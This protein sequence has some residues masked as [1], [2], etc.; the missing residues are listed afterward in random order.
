MS[1]EHAGRLPQLL[2]SAGIAVFLIAFLALP[3]AAQDNAGIASDEAL[4]V[5]EDDAGRYWGKQT[6]SATSQAPQYPREAAI[7]GASGCVNI[8]FIIQPDGT[9]TGY[10]RL[11]GR[12]SF[13][14]GGQHAAVLSQFTRST[15]AMLKKWRYQPG[16]DNPDR[17]RG[18]ASLHA[19][20]SLDAIGGHEWT[21]ACR[22][23]K[24]GEFIQSRQASPSGQ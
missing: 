12:S 11:I 21:D 7:A 13:H 8:G 10:R 17:L 5:E 16:P 1:S 4:L 20:F 24:L 6:E 3:A 22:I 15:I 19:A 23:R 2:R 18:F 14:A 9:T